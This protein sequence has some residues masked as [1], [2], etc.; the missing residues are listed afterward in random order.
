MSERKFNREQDDTEPVK[1]KPLYLIVGICVVVIVILACVIY[2]YL[3]NKENGSAKVPE[4]PVTEPTEYVI[5]TT[6]CQQDLT[7]KTYNNSVYTSCIQENVVLNFTDVNLIIDTK[8]TENNF[9]FNGI[10]YDKQ[11]INM[12]DYLSAGTFKDI[13]FS[14]NGEDIIMFLIDASTEKKTAIYIFRKNEIIYSSGY[15]ANI[16][17]T[18]GTT[19]GYTK[20]T[21]EGLKPLDCKIANKQTKLYEVGT[22]NYDGTTYKEVFAKNV[23]VSD[24]C[25]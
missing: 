17:Y 21:D 10:Y 24:V 20:Y 2:I 16:V 13:K 18:L 19:I 5:P 12:D 4:E 15:N 25:K 8:K 22:V 9:T 11:K 6:A 7:I 23:L 3:N 14:V 1:F